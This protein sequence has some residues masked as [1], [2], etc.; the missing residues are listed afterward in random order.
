MSDGMRRHVVSAALLSLML[1][2]LP[3]RGAAAPPPA[4]QQLLRVPGIFDV[5]GPMPDGRLLLAASRGLFLVGPGG[6]VQPFAPAYRGESGEAYLAA[7]SGLS[8]P[9][10]GCAFQPDDVF[11]LGLARPGVIRIDAGGRVHPFATFSGSGQPNGIVFDTTGRFGHRLL[12]S[13][14][15]NRSTSV[16]ALDCKGGATV[17]TRS[18]PV[19][20]GGL[21]VAPP[22]FGGAAGDLIAPDEL[23]GAI[24]A[25]RPDGTTAT[26]VASG[27]PAGQDIGVESL[28]FVPPGF[29]DG[30]RAYVADRATSN[31]P[32]PGTDSLLA[33]DATALA[34]AGVREGDLLAATEGGARTIAI[35]CH[36]ECSVREIATGPAVAHGEGHL[37]VTAP[38]VRMVPSQLPVSPD[39]GAGGR[40][41]AGLTPPALAGLG[42]A[43]A[44]A[45]VLTAALWWR[46]RQ[47]RLAR[48]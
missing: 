9:G 18:A 32:H 25:V 4:W 28:G 14:P 41:A 39:L 8:V 10:A 7:S 34:G 29:R 40:A 22:D 36:P 45:L 30:G 1:V 11:V 17:I 47:R 24:L 44:V 15:G 16:I 35:R 12:V 33:L 37:L 48:P 38:T 27:L 21:A 46:R 31:N 20:E 13:I 3:A 6:A 42:A 19:L 5:A 26:V 2:V 23:S 43:A